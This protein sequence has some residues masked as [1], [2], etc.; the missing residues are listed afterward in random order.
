VGKVSS[1]FNYIKSILLYVAALPGFRHLGMVL[2]FF[3]S[4]VYEFFKSIL[5]GS[6]ALNKY[7]SGF[8]AILIFVI[9][10]IM[11]NF[12]GV[13]WYV[14]HLF[15]YFV[16]I[17]LLTNVFKAVIDNIGELSLLSAFAGCFILV[18]NIVSLNTYTPVIFEDDLPAEV[19]EGVIDCVLTVYTSG[20]I[21]DDM[22]DL[23][24][25][26]FFFDTVYFIFM[27]ILFANLV[28]GI[29]I[30][31]FGGLKEADLERE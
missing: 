19:C 26:R 9:A 25:G 14:I 8:L 4:P 18:F 6:S 3:L 13:E 31:G 12:V 27:E 2:S 21:G 29:M 15:D 24:G 17:S 30:D 5:I 16:G 11:G 22:D 28:S 1:A 23:Y 20:A 7:E 10:S